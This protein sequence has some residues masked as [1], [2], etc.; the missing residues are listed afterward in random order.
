MGCCGQQRTMLAN[1]ARS[2]A[3]PSAP[4]LPISPPRTA[5]PAPAI[6]PM[7]A[8]GMVSLR[9][10]ARARVLVS[11]PVS[12]HGYEFSGAEPVRAVDGRDAEA[13]LRTGY[14]RPA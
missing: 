13:L 8:M 1:R 6:P 11:G 9:Y 5:S 14:F 4:T 7:G 2:T 12:G 10:V 3:T